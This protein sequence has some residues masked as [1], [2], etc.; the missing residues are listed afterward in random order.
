[1]SKQAKAA[2]LKEKVEDFKEK[3]T[4]VLKPLSASAD[5][6]APTIPFAPYAND[7][8]SDPFAPMLLEK[9][10]ALANTIWGSRESYNAQ[11]FTYP[12]GKTEEERSLIDKNKTY[13]NRNTVMQ[14]L[15]RLLSINM[16]GSDPNSFYDHMKITD[17][18]K[19]LKK[20]EKKYESDDLIDDDTHE[21]I[22]DN[23]L[24]PTNMYGIFDHHY[25]Q[26]VQF[27]YPTQKSVVNEILNQED[28][29]TIESVI[30]YIPRVRSLLASFKPANGYP[31]KGKRLLKDWMPDLKSF[32]PNLDD[33]RFLSDLSNLANFFNCAL[34]HS[35]HNDLVPA[36]KY[37][38]ASSRSY[39]RLRKA[40]ADLRDTALGYIQKQKSLSDL[41]QSVVDLAA[42]LR[43]YFVDV[44]V[45]VDACFNFISRLGIPFDKLVE[46]SKAR[47]DNSGCPF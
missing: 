3:L 24:M 9:A 13:F 17:L 7:E 43:E 35:V 14:V 40:S 4:E 46:E 42:A 8:Y 44:T 16:L 21:Q 45:E 22:I 27:R 25:R 38:T 29:Q 41:L 39:D 36:L 5:D 12:V 18:I 26:S 34:P 20:L 11:Q 19:K 6:Q 10:N 28:M 31:V 2:E 23:I 32:S 1:M 47:I 33:K 15:S 37:P 30:S